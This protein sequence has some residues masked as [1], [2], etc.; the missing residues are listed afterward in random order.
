M[1]ASN[2]TVLL[3]ELETA[4]LH[5]SRN[6]MSDAVSNFV[7]EA[8]VRKGWPELPFDTPLSLNSNL[9][10]VVVFVLFLF[11]LLLLMLQ[12][13]LMLLLWL[14]DDHPT[15]KDK[16]SELLLV[17]YTAC[18]AGLHQ[19]IGREVAAHFVQALVLKFAEHHERVAPISDEAESVDKQCT[20][21]VLM[22][23][24]L[25]H[26]QVVDAT[27][28]FDLARFASKGK[29]KKKKEESNK[30]QTQKFFFEPQE[31]FFSKPPATGS[32]ED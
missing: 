24:Y 21:L 6:D 8:C 3:P 30:Q 15:H 13:L 4:F 27:L 22:F 14:N 17:V 9:Y 16:A 1:N 26:M 29:G 23:G 19:L 10:S 12:L 11:L 25:F 2:L 32:K 28:L 18:I 5:H 20:N 31:T 7:L